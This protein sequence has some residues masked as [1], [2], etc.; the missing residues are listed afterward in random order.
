VERT[1][2]IWGERWLVRQ[3]S[4]HATAILFLKKGTRCSYH[5]HQ[6]KYNL[7]VVLEGKIGIRTQYGEVVLTRG[8]EFT[9]APGE[10][11]KHEF[12]VYEKAVVL[13]EMFVQYNSEDI[14]R[15]GVGGLLNDRDMEVGN[16]S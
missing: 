3:D 11:W 7:F 5:Y 10:E 16:E 9:T 15:F 2:K 14:I 1:L 6:A 8:Q 12:R 13:E 4:T